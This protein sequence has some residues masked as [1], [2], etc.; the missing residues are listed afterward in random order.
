MTQFPR[1]TATRQPHA[2]GAALRAVSAVLRAAVLATPGL[3][4]A[5]AIHAQDEVTRTGGQG[6]VADDCEFGADS[7]SL[8]I[9]PDGS[10]VFVFEGAISECQ[11]WRLEADRATGIDDTQRELQ[12]SGNIR[13]GSASASLTADEL[14]LLG[15]R[16]PRSEWHLSGNVEMRLDGATLSADRATFFA[17]GEVLTL[18]E[19]SGSP[20]RFEHVDTRSGTISHGSGERIEFDQQAG[21]MR[22][23]GVARITTRT[24]GSPG[25]EFTGCDVLYDIRLGRVTYGGSDCGES[26]RI[27]R[28]PPGAGDG[29]QTP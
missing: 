11:G 24:E 13:I 17:E 12:M 21:T 28:V 10:Q 27:R 16:E 7:G 29:D 5:N 6:S 18:A 8:R 1:R 4:L 25:S 20:A 23:P 15:M 9:E 2:A 22:L 3:L 26:I 19:L 14:Q